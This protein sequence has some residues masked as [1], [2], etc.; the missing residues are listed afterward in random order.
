MGKFNTP[1]LDV[2]Q[3]LAIISQMFKDALVHDDKAINLIRK[4][5]TNQLNNYWYSRERNAN[6]I[7]SID[8]FK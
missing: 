7:Y 8:S 3:R 5:Y 6:R 4:S 1:K 2:D